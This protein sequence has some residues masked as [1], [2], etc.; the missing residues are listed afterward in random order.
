M[1]C[2]AVL[3]IIPT[4]QSDEQRKV[5]DGEIRARFGNGCLRLPKGEW[6]I[7][8]ETVLELQKSA[9]ELCSEVRLTREAIDKLDS[10]LDKIEERVSSVTHKLYAASVVVAILVAVGAFVI[11]K[12]WDA[13]AEHLADVAKAAVRSDK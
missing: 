3:M 5:L 8:Y 13:A 11:N 4:L 1:Q 9:G 6:L 10:R 2:M 12:A 7:A